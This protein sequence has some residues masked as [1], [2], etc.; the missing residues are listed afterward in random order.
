MLVWRFK[1][2]Y[3]QTSFILQRCCLVV[4]SPPHQVCLLL[5][6]RDFCLTLSG[7]WQK[8]KLTAVEESRQAVSP[9]SKPT[10][11]G[12]LV[13]WCS[14]GGTGVPDNTNEAGGSHSLA[15]WNFIQL[16]NCKCAFIV[17]N[18]MSGGKKKHPFFC[19][20]PHWCMYVSFSFGLFL[21]SDLALQ[22]GTY[23]LWSNSRSVIIRVFFPPENAGTAG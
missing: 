16:I 20:V 12:G 18:R 13:L 17:L 23:V 19:F 3:T 6:L 10:S 21:N 7:S 22:M 14:A 11:L 15:H 1:N 2:T 8:E 5:L 4:F 9:H